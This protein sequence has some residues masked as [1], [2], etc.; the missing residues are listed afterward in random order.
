MKELYAHHKDWHQGGGNGNGNGNN[1]NGNNGNGNNNV[2]EIDG[3][4]LPLAMLCLFCI[5]LL[6]R[7][8]RGQR[9]TTEG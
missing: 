8:I 6:L 9:K 5:W 3:A 1:G 4:G 7:T 2:P